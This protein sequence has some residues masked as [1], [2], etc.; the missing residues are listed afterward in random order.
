MACPCLPLLCIPLGTVQAEDKTFSEAELDQMLAPIALYPDAL[1]SQILMAS[2]YPADVDEAIK[3]S[4]DN[5]KQE[6][7]AAVKAVQDKS[8]DPSVMSL[9]AFPQ[10]LSM[11]GEQQDWVQNLGDVFLASS[12]AVMDSV[13]KLR[14]KAKQEGNLETTEQQKI[15]VEKQATE[16]V[17]IIEPADPQIVYVPVYNTTVVYGTWWWPHYRPWY[18]YP[19]GYRYGFGG[20]VMRGIGFGVGIGIT[21]SL[22]GSCRWGRGHGSVDIN[23]NKY[24]NINVNNK[25]NSNNKKS[26]WKH[27]SNNRRG[28][29]YADSKSRKQFENKRG[30]SEQRKDFRGR[31]AQ[32]DNARSTL[33]KRG[34]DPA[35]AR[36]QLQGSAGDKARSSVNKANRDV[37]QGKLGNNQGFNSQQN[38]SRDSRKS[39][40]TGN[41]SNRSRDNALKGAGNA[42]KSRQ[43]INRGNSSNRSMHNR[44]SS[45]RSGGGGRRGGGRRR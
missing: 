26:N 30:G 3:W 34:V 9:V 21:N 1:L 45:H 29:P 44:G 6:G 39:A 24:N 17:I 31:D 13:Q 40:N 22:W 38:R 5:P 19:P 12:E 42:N 35:T 28:V 25:I 27:N 43:N 14:N 41:H 20:A 33:D 23:V 10:V 16:S 7:D 32:R 36:T 11:M 15:V 4:K 37:A 2:T 8:W 18:Y